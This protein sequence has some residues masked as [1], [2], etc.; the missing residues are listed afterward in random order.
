[1]MKR[2]IFFCAGILYWTSALLAQTGDSLPESDLMI[3]ARFFEGNI[4]IRWAPKNPA[5]WSAGNRYGYR[6]ERQRLNSGETFSP[7]RF[8]P[9]HDQ[10]LRP[11]TLGEFEKAS[12]NFP[13]NN[14]IPAAAECI[15][16]SGPSAG[17][18][19][20]GWA[21]ASDQLFNRFSLG[22]FSAEMHFE[23]AI[24]SGL[25]FRDEDVNPSARYLYRLTPLKQDGAEGIPTFVMITAQEKPPFIPE[26]NLPTEAENQVVIHWSRKLHQRYF[27]AYWI[28]KS[29]DGHSWDRLNEAPYVHAL[30]SDERVQTD[31]ISYQDSVENYK[32]AY[33]RIIGIDGFG[34]D[35]PPSAPLKAMG[36]DRTA[37]PVVSELSTVILENGSVQIN[38][39]A[40][41]MPSDLAGFKVQRG[42]DYAGPREVL[43]AAILSPESRSFTD[44]SPNFVGI[45]YYEIIS[46]DTAGNQRISTPVVG[47]IEDHTPP[48]APARPSASIDSTGEV[49]LSWDPN[50]EPDI[51]GYKVFFANHLHEHFVGL[52]QSP[53]ERLEFRDTLSLNT[54]SKTIFYRIAAVD[55]RGNTSK[56]SDI[57][58]VQR[59]D[60]ISPAKAL[61]RQYQVA[62]DTAHLQWIPSTS[63]D[64]V[65]QEVQRRTDSQTWETV[66]RLSADQDTWVDID[67][68]P[69]QIYTY[70]IITYDDSGLK[71]TSRNLSL[72]T[73]RITSGPELEIRPRTEKKMIQLSWNG[74]SS[75]ISSWVLYRAVENQSMQRVAII[76]GDKDIF[77]DHTVQSGVSYHYAIRA[78]YQDGVKGV[79]SESVSAKM[80]Y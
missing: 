79:L 23:T 63:D 55:R 16:R 2:L 4:L 28:E 64:V 48:E 6:L 20:Q 22:L 25:A 68:K 51:R 7:E 69:H 32:P 74:A 17:G 31:L 27:S 77:E 9:L 43:T 56:F 14:Y 11:A 53:I 80:F 12:A 52:T 29:E 18:L 19:G 45:N 70:R 44:Q 73:K 36:R 15:Y 66:A 41:D 49:I 37:P 26:T 42:F 3:Q 59:I 13:A 72:R 47:F 1:M 71:S 33:Y 38:W 67:V 30:S 76:S 8:T 60:T 50:P 5:V 75:N 57:L 62:A 39:K 35:S 10:P 61:F 34:M 40:E 78:V 54:L 65:R 58:A 46:I 24:L 21:D